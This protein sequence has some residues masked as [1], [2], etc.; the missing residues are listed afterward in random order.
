MNNLIRLVGRRLLLLPIMV[1]GV[2]FLVFVLMSL[3]P[4][5]P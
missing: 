5:D 1:L 2:T 4:I 3:S